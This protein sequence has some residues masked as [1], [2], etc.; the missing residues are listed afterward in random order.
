[1]TIIVVVKKGSGLNN[2]K[3]NLRV[4]VF[5]DDEAMVALLE[6]VLNSLGYKVQ[7]FPDPDIWL[8]NRKMECP[9]LLDRPCA[10]IIISDIMMPNMSGVDFIKQV[11]KF[12]CKIAHAH[13]ALMSASETLIQ[14]ASEQ[15]LG[16]HSFK[17]PFKMA[18]LSEWVR[19]CAK[20]V[21]C[22]D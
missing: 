18:E 4:L 3:N 17:K 10:D 6:R 21:S 7:A 11:N 22:F 1:M 13:K 19:S 15:E 14:N 9:C 12:K 5:E 8:A 20:R 2:D 16:C